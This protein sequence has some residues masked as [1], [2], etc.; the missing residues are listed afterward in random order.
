MM[1]RLYLHLK[2]KNVVKV[3]PP[4]TKLTGYTHTHTRTHTHTHTYLRTHTHRKPFDI[5]EFQLRPVCQIIYSN[6]AIS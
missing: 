3:E 5:S 1:A 2:K 6:T 4:L